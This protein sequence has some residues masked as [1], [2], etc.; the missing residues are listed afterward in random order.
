MIFFTGSFIFPFKP[1]E[2]RYVC[3]YNLTEGDRVPFN[4]KYL[5]CVPSITFSMLDIFK[6]NFGGSIDNK[7]TTLNYHKFLWGVN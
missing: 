6:E 2:I 1:L 4:F 3:L 7:R 5:H